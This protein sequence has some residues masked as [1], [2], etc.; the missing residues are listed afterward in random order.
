M[1]REWKPGDVAMMTW[2]GNCDGEFAVI[3]GDGHWQMTDWLDG[4]KRD[5]DE[6]LTDSW[7]AKLTPTIRPLVVIDPEDTE[8]IKELVQ[9]CN[10]Y[11]PG[12]FITPMV[13][14]LQKGLRELAN[15]QPPRPEE[16]MGLGAVVEDGSGLW[17]RTEHHAAGWCPS[18]SNSGP[19]RCWQ[20][21]TNDVRVLSEGVQP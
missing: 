14:A 4:N 6:F 16:P 1:S 5:D 15:P 3:R 19:Y 12:E 10:F 17:V 9:R 7:L 8:A 2:P 13:D 11:R 21:M 18:G 20:D